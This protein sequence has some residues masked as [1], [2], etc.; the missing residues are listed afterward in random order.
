MV[1]GYVIM[2]VSG[3]LKGYARSGYAG[4]YGLCG[5]RRGAAERAWRAQVLWPALSGQGSV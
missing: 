1:I 2:R 3:V 4:G 5:L